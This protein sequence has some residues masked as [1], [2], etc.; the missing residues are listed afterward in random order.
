MQ[1]NFLKL[2]LLLFREKKKLYT[3]SHDAKRPSM[4]ATLTFMK[5]CADCCIFER[6]NPT[7][8]YCSIENVA[9]FMVFVI[10]NVFVVAF[11]TISFKYSKQIAL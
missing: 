5:K 7:G 9:A 10:V 11:V 8:N 4:Q 2:V 1:W 6:T 3:Y